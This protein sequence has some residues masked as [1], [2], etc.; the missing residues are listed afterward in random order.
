MSGGCASVW[1]EQSQNNTVVRCRDVLWN[2]N[3]DSGSAVSIFSNRRVPEVCTLHLHNMA[4]SFHGTDS[5]ALS[6]ATQKDCLWA[7][8][9]HSL[10]AQVEASKNK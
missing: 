2:Y 10:H 9:S 3:I 4:Q 8:R 1:P 5:S 7:C 6:S